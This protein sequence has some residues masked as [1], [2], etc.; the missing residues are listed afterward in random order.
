MGHG[1]IYGHYVGL[2]NKIYQKI[3]AVSNFI[4]VEK[5]IIDMRKSIIFTTNSRTTFL[6]P[7]K[8][9]SLISTLLLKQQYK[10]NGK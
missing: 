7:K 2:L 9:V 10:S 4:P 1:N 8:L 3:V 5:D 6:K